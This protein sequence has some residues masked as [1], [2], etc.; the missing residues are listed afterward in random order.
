MYRTPKEQ[1]MAPKCTFSCKLK[2]FRKINKNLSKNKSITSCLV[3][4]NGS[5]REHLLDLVGTDT[6]LELIV[7]SR[8]DDDRV[9]SVQLRHVKIVGIL[10]VLK[11]VTERVT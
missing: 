7:A 3:R 8:L 2:F 5:E 1:T 4:M 9:A 10:F 11:S 6:E